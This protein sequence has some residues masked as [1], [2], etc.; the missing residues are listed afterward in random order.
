MLDIP[1][2]AAT[3]LLLTFKSGTGFKRL[4]EVGRIN[5]SD[6]LIVGTSSYSEMNENNFKKSNRKQSASD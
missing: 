4:S 2:V 1:F 3:K 6:E 5:V